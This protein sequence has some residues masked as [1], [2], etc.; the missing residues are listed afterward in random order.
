MKYLRILTIPA[1]ALL[2]LSSCASTAKIEKDETVDFSKFKSYKWVDNENGPPKNLL[3][4]DLQAAVNSKL[5]AEAKWKEDNKSPD[6]LIT[7]DLQVEKKLEERNSPVYSQSYTRQY[8]NP[9]TRRWM[10]VYYPSRVVGYDNDQ[11]EV[12]EG[13][14]TITMIDAKTDQVIWQGWN[15]DQVD[16]KNVTSKEIQSAVKSIFKK[17]EVKK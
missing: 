2:F 15:T 4:R 14:I 11:Y 17:F 9:R 16:N 12:N 6:V 8:Y 3:E 13:T 7:H 5:E 1:V 10:S